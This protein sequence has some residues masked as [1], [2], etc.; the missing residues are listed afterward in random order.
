MGACCPDVDTEFA[1]VFSPLF[2]AS[3]LG[4]TIRTKHVPATLRLEGHLAYFLALGADRLEFFRC[5]IRVFTTCLGP[6]F[7]FFE[8]FPAEDRLAWCGSERH[9]TRPPTLVT[10]RLVHLVTPPHSWGRGFT[11]FSHRKMWFFASGKTASPPGWPVW[12]AF[13]YGGF[14]L[15]RS[16]TAREL[17]FRALALGTATA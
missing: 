12:I 5:G 10:D 8:A 15:S 1:L 11:R 6:P 13:A 3:S 17:L 9:F 14:F 2:G 16:G 7:V 4:E